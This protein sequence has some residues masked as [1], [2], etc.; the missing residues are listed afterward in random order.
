MKPKRL[1][2]RISYESAAGV[3]VTFDRKN[4]KAWIDFENETFTY[5]ILE[6]GDVIV[7]ADFG[8]D[9]D[10]I[11]VLTGQ[12]YVLVHEVIWKPGEEMPHARPIGYAT[13]WQYI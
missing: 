10:Y 8:K 2:A 6:D 9:H 3:P 12:V 1:K 7:P 13:D 5:T 4:L 11:S